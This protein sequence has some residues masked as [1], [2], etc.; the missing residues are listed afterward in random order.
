MN[1]WDYVRPNSMRK[2][3][4]FTSLVFLLFLSQL[5]WLSG[6]LFSQ[7]D[8]SAHINKLQTR[9]KFAPNDSTKI[10]SI[11]DAKYIKYIKDQKGEK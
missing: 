3:K 1:A 4:S 11:L 10:E 6:N 8:P 2:N 9:Y 7:F 5:L